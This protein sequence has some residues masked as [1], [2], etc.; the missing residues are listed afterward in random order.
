MFIY[1]L[2]NKEMISLRFFT[3]HLLLYTSFI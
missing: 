2:E 1:R 3:L